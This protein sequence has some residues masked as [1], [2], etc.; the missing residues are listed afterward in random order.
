ML[1]VRNWWRASSWG[2]WHE[3]GYGPGGDDNERC[4]FM[5]VSRWNWKSFG[6]GRERTFANGRE[7]DGCGPVR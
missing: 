5:G 7:E 3:S 2:R 4:G 6:T 1:Q